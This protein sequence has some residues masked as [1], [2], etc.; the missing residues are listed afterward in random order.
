MKKAYQLLHFPLFLC[1]IVS[2]Q[3]MIGRGDMVI[4]A[5]VRSLPI[6]PLERELLLVLSGLANLSSVESFLIT[7]IVVLLFTIAS[8]NRRHFIT[9]LIMYLF[10]LFFFTTYFFSRLAPGMSSYMSA[11]IGT[12]IAVA[13]AVVM[14]FS[15]I[16]ALLY[17]KLAARSVKMLRERSPAGASF[18]KCKNCGAQF[19]SNP[20]Y[21][22]KCLTE[23]A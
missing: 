12:S 14:A 23:M 1:V 21:C 4:Q 2:C 5:G 18:K 22:S 9:C 16:P 11:W 19:V 6:A 17:R 7:G 20:R 8:I 15:G 3:L 13:S 10:F